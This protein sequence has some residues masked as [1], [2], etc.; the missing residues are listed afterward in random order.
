MTIH[1]LTLMAPLTLLTLALA[2]CGSLSP[3]PT[4]PAAQAPEDQSA[5]QPAGKVHVLPLTDL[6][7]DYGRTLQRSSAFDATP[8]STPQNL[9]QALTRGGVHLVYADAARLQANN[10][11]QLAVLKL[12]RAQ[13]VP[14]LIEGGATQ[15]GTFGDVTMAAFDFRGGAGSYLIR[16]IPRTDGGQSVVLLE[17]GSV[18]TANAE[19]D[20]RASWL[21]GLLVGH[22]TDTAAE[23]D[24]P[25]LLQ[26]LAVPAQ[27]W[28]GRKYY[29]NEGLVRLNNPSY[30]TTLATCST[31]TPCTDYTYSTPLKTFGTPSF[32]AAKWYGSWLVCGGTTIV[33]DNNC[34]VSYTDTAISTTGSTN[35]LGFTVGGELNGEASVGDAYN[36]FTLFSEWKASL[37]IKAEIRYDH[38]WLTS[39]TKWFS[40]TDSLSIKQGYRARFGQG[41]Y[42]LNY[43]TQVKGRHERFTNMTFVGGQG[44]A[45]CGGRWD[46]NYEALIECS[47]TYNPNFLGPIA[48]GV[49]KTFGAKVWA[50]CKNID[51]ACIN[52]FNAADT[53]DLPL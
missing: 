13:G 44:G 19:T 26:A 32:K 35:A 6:S 22:A 34:G 8:V 27:L 20:G 1:R 36:P 46:G 52:N 24:T 43:K 9:R 5:S 14:V 53:Y 16:A 42:G 30:V 11:D 28:V 2:G 41:D 33:L 49:I 37:A 50:I 29:G 48:S 10:P 25:T 21:R 31:T 40:T 23:E 17:A 12:A 3:A 38:T 15:P 45:G 51:T 18:Q 4:P 47:M 7:G 39:D